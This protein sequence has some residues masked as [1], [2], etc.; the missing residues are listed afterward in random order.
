[1]LLSPFIP[2][3]PS[4]TVSKMSMSPLHQQPYRVVEGTINKD[5]R[6]ILGKPGVP[7]VCWNWL[8]QALGASCIHYIP[9][10]QSVS[11]Y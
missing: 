7:V 3:S 11:L 4:P 10:L 6:T 9:T 5:A 8:L 2:L 1:M